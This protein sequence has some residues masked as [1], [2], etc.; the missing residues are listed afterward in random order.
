[1]ALTTITDNHSKD[2]SRDEKIIFKGKV[3]TV[4]F[5]SEHRVKGMV[6]IFTREGEFPIIVAGERILN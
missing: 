1:M 3:W 2:L 5:V 6:R 4:D